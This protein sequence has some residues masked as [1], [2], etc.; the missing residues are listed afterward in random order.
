MAVPLQLHR[1]TPSPARHPGMPSL[2]GGISKAQ[3]R[4][5]SANQTELPSARKLGLS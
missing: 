2:T 1:L 4:I 3:L 5:M